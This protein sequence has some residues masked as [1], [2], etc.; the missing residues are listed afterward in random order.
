[1]ESQAT[2]I[3]IEF[4]RQICKVVSRLYLKQTAGA[5]DGGGTWKGYGRDTTSIRFCWTRVLRPPSLFRRT[6][7]GPNVGRDPKDSASGSV[8][9][10]TSD[11]T[12][13]RAE[14]QA[15]KTDRR[16]FRDSRW[17]HESQDFNAISQV[18]V[19][20]RNGYDIFV[21]TLTRTSLACKCNHR[22]VPDEEVILQVNLR[23][24]S[25]TLLFFKP[26]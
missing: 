13:I 9:H 2:A 1:M 22:P 21:A 19:V 11:E 12:A 16:I 17:A 20:E 7:N 8:C 5:K 6:G 10:T 26:H 25:T 23:E 3:I 4:V 14:S 15:A 24:Y 18:P